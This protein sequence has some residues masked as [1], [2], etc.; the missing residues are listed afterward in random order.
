MYYATGRGSRQALL[1]LL[2]VVG[3]ELGASNQMAS[4][5]LCTPGVTV[6]ECP[7]EECCGVA[8]S[9]VHDVLLVDVLL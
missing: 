5:N 8:E 1:H 6:V 9:F 7:V 3:S 2:Q 4:D